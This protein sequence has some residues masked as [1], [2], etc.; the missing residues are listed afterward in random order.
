M[1]DCCIQ[2]TEKTVS[3]QTVLIE[4]KKNTQKTVTDQTV[5]KFE[6]HMILLSL[7]YIYLSTSLHLSEVSGIFD[8]FCL[9]LCRLDPFQVKM[10][11]TLAYTK[12]RNC[13]DNCPLRLS[14]QLSM[15][16]SI[17]KVS[18]GQISIR[19]PCFLAERT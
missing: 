16:K 5:G 8:L 4:I 13:Q 11:G 15:K 19:F 12:E 14:R 3:D 17:H 1:I 6:I 7:Y 2:K 18:Y 9:Y 10:L